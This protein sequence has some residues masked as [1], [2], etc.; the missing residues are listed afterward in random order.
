MELVEITCGLVHASYSLPEWQVVK[1]TFFAPCLPFHIHVL[2]LV[3]SLPFVYLK[4][5]KVPLLP[6]ASVYKPLWE[7]PP[8]LGFI[9]YS[10]PKQ[11][12]T[13]FQPLFFESVA[14]RNMSLHVHH[15]DF[16]SSSCVFCKTHCVTSDIYCSP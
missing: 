6:I 15:M 3:K 12:T 14:K 13:L 5:E 4:P 2:Q 11:H 10:L 1:L 8:P 9:A 7:Y 16:L